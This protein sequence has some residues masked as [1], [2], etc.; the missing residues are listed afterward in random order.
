MNILCILIPAIVGIITAILGYLLGRN[1]VIKRLNEQISELE[2]DLE[3]CK[4]KRLKLEED[5]DTLKQEHQK[6]LEALRS[7]LRK[8]GSGFNVIPFD[9]SL[10]K[11]VFNK[12]IK[13]NDLEVIEGIGPKI[14]E[15]LVAAGIATWKQLS[16]TSV[17]KCQEILSKGGSQFDL[18]N[19]DTWGKQAK[20]A[21]E[22]KWQE[23]KDWQESL[24]GGVE[25]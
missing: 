17:E 14:K 7:Q 2:S 1:A 20:L 11:S 3:F 8:G 22:G 23:L 24:D 4:S 10:A 18:H 12:A 5:I 25:E 6:E 9:K 15:L 21:Y 13:E 19:P 16:E